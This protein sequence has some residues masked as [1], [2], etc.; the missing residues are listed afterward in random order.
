[1]HSRLDRVRGG[2]K[3]ILKSERIFVAASNS[4]AQPEYVAPS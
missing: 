4:D 1:M 2:M 3:P